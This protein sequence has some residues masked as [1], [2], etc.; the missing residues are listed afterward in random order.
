MTIILERYPIP[1]RGPLNVRLEVSTDIKVSADEARRKVN[2]FLLNNLSHLM[3]SERQP[4]LVV[5]ERVVWRVAVNH[6]LPGFGA[7]GRI[8]TID[9][10]VESGELQP[11][12]PEQLEEM[13]HRAKTLA[14]RYPL[15]TSP[16]G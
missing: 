13:K 11:V 3:L 12:S 10:D 8:G 7:L 14:G 6:T 16:A 5:G 1:E 2:G 4:E 15:D 9:V